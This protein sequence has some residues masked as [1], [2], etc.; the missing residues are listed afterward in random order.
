MDNIPSLKLCFSIGMVAFDLFTGVTGKPTLW[1][2]I[3]KWDREE[4]KS[5]S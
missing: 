4:V 2:G 3:G 1:L 5:W